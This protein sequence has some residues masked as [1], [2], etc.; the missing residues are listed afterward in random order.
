MFPASTG[1]SSIEMYE[2]M[3]SDLSIDIKKEKDRKGRN[4]LVAYAARLQNFE[5]VDYF[6]SKGLDIHS[7]DAKGNGVFHYAAQTGDEVIMRK[8]AEDYKVKTGLNAETNENAILFATT[9]F[10][11]SGA[12]TDLSFYQFLEKEYNLDPTIVSKEGKN[13]L[14]NLATRTKN[15]ELI[16]HFVSK[17]VDPN[18][19]DKEGNNV[20]ILASAKGNKDM[21]QYL[22]EN[23]S[24]I[25]LSNKEGISALTRAVKSNSLEV[26]KLLVANGAEVKI[27]DRVGNNL[28]YHLVDAYNG[29]MDEF[30]EKLTYLVSLGLDV[31]A[32]QSAGATLL[33]HA[34]NKNSKELL[35][36]L[37]SYG[38]DINATDEN[39]ET[40]LH[41]A[42]LQ[43]QDEE[44]LKY[45]VAAGAEKSITTE[46]EESAYDLA[47]NNEKL[48]GK[49]I[50]FL[51]D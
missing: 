29:K 3:L 4:A 36:T 15:L 34:V 31:Q 22:V 16:K 17:G 50:E 46:F 9:R 40:V 51:K 41:K 5:M 18:Q 23:T 21:I 6:I 25:S 19:L 47:K 26:A 13:A 44:I 33:H 12:E 24:D 1:Q 7:T 38:I 42:A 28:G 8:L 49:D 35:E 2:Y 14:H 27:V 45:L 30:K 43:S 32:E 39:G 20:L 37:V 10:S 11:R 48:A